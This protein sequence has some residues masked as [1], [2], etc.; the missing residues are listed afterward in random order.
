MKTW[1]EKLR[2]DLLEDVVSIDNGFFIFK[3]NSE[4]A[5]DKILEDGPYYV[6][7]RLIV[8][9]KWQP[10]LK[11]SKCEFFSVLLWV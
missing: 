1:A 9:K 7:A 11:L 5:I 8:V 6:G 10:G 2:G 3:V 4:E